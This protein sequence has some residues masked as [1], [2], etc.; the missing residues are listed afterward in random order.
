MK[1]SFNNQKVRE[2]INNLDVNK[3]LE[4][5]MKKDIIITKFSNAS[6]EGITLH[7]NKKTSLKTNNLQNDRLWVSWDKIGKLLFSNYADCISVKDRDKLR[8]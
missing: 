8:K 1:L 6:S 3:D 4:I 7:L 2:M 5:E